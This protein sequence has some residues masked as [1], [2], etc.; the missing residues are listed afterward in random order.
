MQN[1]KRCDT[2]VTVRDSSGGIWRDF[3]GKLLKVAAVSKAAW[4]AGI[5]LVVPAG[6][7]G[8]EPATLG[9]GDR[10]STS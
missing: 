3:A 9:F 2:S 8:L 6:E 7:T 10:C 4:E 5:R 1:T